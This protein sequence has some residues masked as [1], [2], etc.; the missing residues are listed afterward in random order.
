MPRTQKILEICVQIY[1]PI[2]YGCI[3]GVCDFVIQVI[4]KYLSIPQWITLCKHTY[5]EY[6]LLLFYATYKKRS[7]MILELHISISVK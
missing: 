3:T 6:N 7:N 2:I 4:A 1:K 5:D